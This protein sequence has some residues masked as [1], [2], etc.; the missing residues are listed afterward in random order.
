[1]RRRALLLL[2]LALLLGGLA[3]SVFADDGWKLEK[4]ADG[5]RIESRAVPGW[6]IHEMRGTV[7]ID[8]PLSAV[9]AVIDDASAIPRLNDVV[10][11]A[12][13]VQRTSAT[14][15][16]IYAAM[17]MPWPV[18]DRDIVNQREIKLDPAT[19]GVTFVDTAVPDAETHKDYVRIVKSR[20]EWRLTPTGDG[21][22]DVQIQLLSDPGGIPSTLINAM[23][24]S[25]PFNT[26]GNLRKLAAQ[27]PYA[28]AKPAFLATPPSSASAGR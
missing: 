4:D 13:V 27:A 28:G 25:S 15:Y 21:R 22:T 5:I 26:L 12:E 17:K 9:A 20:Q 14:R 1:M 19:H 23:S 2:P 8:A 6:K 10:A 7:Q 18:S 3:P 16:R 24:V 11:H